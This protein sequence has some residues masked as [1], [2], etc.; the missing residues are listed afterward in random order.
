MYNQSENEEGQLSIFAE[1]GSTS[2]GIDLFEDYDNIPSNVQK[3]LD[4][5][6]DAFMDGSYTGLAKALKE[7][8]KIGYTFE[9]YLD[10]AAYDLR[11]IGTKGKSE[12][13]EDYEKGGMMAEGGDVTPKEKMIKE[14]QKLQRELNSSRLS[15]Y[16]EGDESDNQKSL[17]RERASKLAR[18][19]EIL[20]ILNQDDNKMADGGMMADGG[21][22]SLYEDYSEEVKDYLKKSGYTDKEIKANFNK[23]AIENGF[24]YDEEDERWY[25]NKADGGMMADGGKINYSK[26]WKVVGIDMQGRMFKKEI[27]LGRI[28]DKND[29]MNALKRMPDTN[30]RE[31]TS[32]EEIKEDGGM[33]ADGGMIS[34]SKY[35]KTL[36][37]KELLV[38][39]KVFD[40]NNEEFVYIKDVESGIFA[41]KNK[42]DEL[43]HYYRMYDLMIEEYADGGYMA[44]GGEIEN[45][46]YEM[47]ES[48]IVQIKHHAKELD[49]IDNVEIEAWVL[50]KAQRAATDLSDITH[51]LEGKK[52]E[53]KKA[54][55]EM[56]AKGGKTTV[57]DEVSSMSF[58]NNYDDY[59][60]VVISNDQDSNRVNKDRFLVSAKNINEAKEIATKM[61]KERNE[62]T[63]LKVM[64]DEEYRFNYI[65]KM[66][67]GGMMA[68][69]GY[70]AK[71]G[72]AKMGGDMLY[73][74]KDYNNNL[75][76]SEIDSTKLIKWAKGYSKQNNENPKITNVEEAISYIQKKPEYYVVQGI[77]A[78]RLKSRLFGSNFFN[79][80]NDFYSESRKSEIARKQNERILRE[81]MGKDYM[82]KGGGF[83]QNGEAYGFDKDEYYDMISQYDRLCAFYE[84]AESDIE[85]KKLN[86]KINA[87][88]D[89]INAYERM[90]HGGYMAKGGM[91]VTS[92]KD[93]PNFKKR[94]DE[95]KITYR[96]LGLGKLWDDFNKLTGTTGTRIKVDGKEYFITDEEFNTF[97]RGADGKLRI[98]FEAPFR[99]SYEDGGYMAKGGET[100]DSEYR[101]RMKQFGFKPYGNTKGNYKI[102]F[103]ED[104]K[105]QSEIWESKEMA[106]DREKKLLKIGN[107]NIKITKLPSMKM[108]GKVTFEDK[109][110]SIK[111]SLLK[112][113]TVSP[114]VQKDYGKTYNKKEALESAQRIAGA[115]KAKYNK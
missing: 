30:I 65:N 35:Y 31:V 23:L 96:G 34:L 22:T 15:Q 114:K 89:K 115:M 105:K 87:L 86:V 62:G 107:T 70:M 76:K 106:E 46:N 77:Y 47:L 50:S 18:F 44:E 66:A 10:G 12:D 113:K 2:E 42:N 36:P 4:K 61:W 110:S 45:E 94:L 68:D 80:Q 99:K 55:G 85:R 1:G 33:M 56:M 14:L 98:R 67:D 60:M 64:S 88:E 24:N 108:G 11:P 21:K 51:Y 53:E 49:D 52:I 41:G 17:Q 27:T 57:I 5:Y 13:D 19:N 104:G 43:G 81:I 59:E 69:G 75:V 54:D 73:D 29:V 74:I 84:D 63:I 58:K 9:Y 100:S 7:L 79:S 48:L 91:V 92:I 97:S 93:I 111:K 90:E 103:I 37:K 71:G 26:K 20:K 28:S 78:D 40:K 102:E 112:K 39:L 6:E 109:V 38:G 72:V 82:A 16:I 95:G 8:E 3:V 83:N 101:K 25:K 32:I